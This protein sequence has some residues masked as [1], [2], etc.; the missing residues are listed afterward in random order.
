MLTSKKDFHIFR[1]A[2]I[3]TSLS[4]HYAFSDLLAPQLKLQPRYVDV[5]MDDGN[6]ENVPTF[7]PGTRKVFKM[8]AIFEDG[9]G[10]RHYSSENQLIVAV[11]KAAM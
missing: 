2:R 8:R 4:S 1:P 11:N 7:E 10:R 9:N 5:Q 6:G 3:G